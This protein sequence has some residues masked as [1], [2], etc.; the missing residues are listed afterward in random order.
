MKKEYSQFTLPPLSLSSLYSRCP[1]AIAREEGITQRGADLPVVNYWIRQTGQHAPASYYG[2]VQMLAFSQGTSVSY[3]RAL[4]VPHIAQFH[5]AGAHYLADLLQQP[6]PQTPLLPNPMSSYCYSLFAQQATLLT[7]IPSWQRKASYSSIVKA[8]W[9]NSYPFTMPIMEGQVAITASLPSSCHFG[10]LKPTFTF[11]IPQ[12]GRTHLF[13]QLIFIKHL[14]LLSTIYQSLCSQC[15][16]SSQTPANTHQALPRVLKPHH[17]CC[18]EPVCSC[19]SA[20]F[21]SWSGM[22]GYFLL[23]LESLT[24]VCKKFKATSLWSR[25]SA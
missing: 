23:C 19:Y 8:M 14:Y 11:W 17:I 20:S 15:P 3:W 5:D 9:R 22:P 21:Q 2:R 7:D 6:P 4:S 18:T 10:L 25:T 13:I 24:F 1:H 16:P 12:V